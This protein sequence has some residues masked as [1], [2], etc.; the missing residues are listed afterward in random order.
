MRERLPQMLEAG[1]ETARERSISS[2]GWQLAREYRHL[3][4][5]VAVPMELGKKKQAHGL[6]RK[7]VLAFLKVPMNFKNG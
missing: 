1:Y 6:G 7:E 3:M 2:V 4:E 5:P